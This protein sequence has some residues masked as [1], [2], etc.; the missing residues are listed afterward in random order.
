MIKKD[1]GLVRDIHLSSKLRNRRSCY[2]F[3]RFA[4]LDE[5]ERVARI[6]N[7]MHVY[8]WPILA[9]VANLDWNRRYKNQVRHQRSS[10]GNAKPMT[11]AHQRSKT[12]NAKPM[13]DVHR[14][15]F[16]QTFAIGSDLKNQKPSKGWR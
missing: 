1:C 6:T 5:A 12:I 2:A 15:N 3:V 14:D 9:K 7:G 10:I 4:T 11:E 16:G 8:G 13:T